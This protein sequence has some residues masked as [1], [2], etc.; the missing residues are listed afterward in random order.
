MSIFR[1][2]FYRGNQYQYTRQ[3][4]TNHPVYIA[5]RDTLES[6][7]ASGK[8]C[9]RSSWSGLLTDG[10]R[11]DVIAENVIVDVFKSH[12]QYAY[13]NDYIDFDTSLYDGITTGFHGETEATYRIMM[14]IPSAAEE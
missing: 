7:I 5:F 9:I 2:F 1:S 11:A 12:P 10:N 6:Q 3:N 8:T 14:E 4:Y 13:G